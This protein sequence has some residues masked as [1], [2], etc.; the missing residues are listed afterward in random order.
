[1][2]LELALH[3]PEAPG[4]YEVCLARVVDT[5]GLIARASV[6]VSAPDPA[7]APAR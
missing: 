3:V 2:T 6:E 5:A 7:R 4:L 1:M